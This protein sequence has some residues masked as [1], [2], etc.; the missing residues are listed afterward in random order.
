[1]QFFCIPKTLWCKK[2]GLPSLWNSKAIFWKLGQ[3]TILRRDDGT[4]MHCPH[5]GCTQCIGNTHENC[6][7][8][9]QEKDKYVA[10]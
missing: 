7:A 5:E 2:C 3:P 4:F 8:L 9:T 10:L 1:M 6:G